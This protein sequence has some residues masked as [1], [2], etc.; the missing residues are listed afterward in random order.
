MKQRFK[1][2]YID[3]A[4]R[5]AQMSYATRLKV[6][7][8]I[9]K[10]DRILSIGYNGT[11]SGW[12][13][14]CEIREYAPDNIEIADGTYPHKEFHGEFSDQ[15]QLYRLKT[16]PE[17]I[18][19]ERNALDKIAKSTESSNGA[20]LFVTHSPCLECAKSIFTTGITSV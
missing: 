13:N 14:E 8:I 5:V 12:S 19:A 18:H 7:A 1:E 9:V 11:P 15:V 3:I 6:G 2:L 4:S 17:T 20:S 16:K 10:D